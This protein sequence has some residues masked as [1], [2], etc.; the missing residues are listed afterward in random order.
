VTPG[1]YDPDP[2]IRMRVDDLTETSEL[3][4][5]RL[6]QALI[7]HLPGIAVVVFDRELRVVW[8]G[9]ASLVEGGGE[10]GSPVAETVPAV[11]RSRV[12][13]ACALA[14]EGKSGVLRLRSADRRTLFAAEVFPLDADPG[15]ERGMIVAR[16]VTD[17]Q[18]T[19]ALERAASAREEEQLRI[20]LELHDDTLQALTAALIA[21]D[22]VAAAQRRGDGDGSAEAVAD[23]RRVLGEATERT[24]RIALAMRPPSLRDEI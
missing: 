23:A 21:L 4:P 18:R 22:R 14:L 9:G 13:T 2:E 16:D 1:A 17:R 19:T 12:A 8:A 10:P 24:R 15:A 3:R 20:A 11:A 6:W 5:E 7:A